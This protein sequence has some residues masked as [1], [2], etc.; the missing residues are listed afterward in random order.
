MELNLMRDIVEE[1]NNNTYIITYDLPY[2]LT[3]EEVEE[4]E[5]LI[6]NAPEAYSFEMFPSPCFDGGVFL[7]F[8]RLDD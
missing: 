2:V 3:K 4:I 7:R 1:I 5:N 8:T 6:E